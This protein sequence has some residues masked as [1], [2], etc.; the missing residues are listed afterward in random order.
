MSKV[1]FA[2]T[3]IATVALGATGATLAQNPVLNAGF[4]QGLDGWELRI[5]GD[6]GDVAVVESGAAGRQCALITKTDSTPQWSAV[7]IVQ[8][9]PVE[10]NAVYQLSL[11]SRSDLEEKA[12]S[13]AFR[14]FIAPSGAPGEDVNRVIRSSDDWAAFRWEYSTGPKTERITVSILLTYSSGKVWIDDVRFE[15]QGQS[16]EAESFPETSGARAAERGSLSG[17]RGVALTGESEIATRVRLPE[18][19]IAV[20]VFGESGDE[21]L[22]RRS[23]R[24][25]LGDETKIV[26]LHRHGVAVH[27]RVAYFEVDAAG[28]RELVIS[29]TPDYEGEVVVDRVFW[30]T[31]DGPAR[32]KDLRLHTVLVQSGEP[33]A[34]I[35]ASDAPAMRALADRLQAEIRK[36]SGATLPVMR[37]EELMGGEYE[38]TTAIAI[39]NLMQNKLS[40]RLYCLWYTREDGW[41]PGKG[42]YVIRSVH[43]LWGTGANVLVLAGSDEQGT[44]DAVNRLLKSLKPGRDIVLG[45]TI[46]VTMDPDVAA[47]FGSPDAD[48]AVRSLP[49]R[50]QRSLMSTSA[51]SGIAYQYTGDPGWADVFRVYLMEHKRRPE[52][53]HDTHMELW[54][55]IRAWDVLEECPALTDEDRLE[56][57]N[58]LLYVLRSKEGV[59]NSMFVGSLNYSSVRHNHHMLAALDAYY[60]GLYFKHYY[61][62]PDADDWLAKARFCFASQELQDKGQDE[63]GNYEGS[64]SLKS[65]V[66]FAYGEPGYRFLPSGTGRRFLDRVAM[67]IDNRFSSSGHGD[68]WDVNCFPA[69]ALRVGAWYYGDGRYQYILNGRLRERPN[70][71]SAWGGEPPFWMDGYLA[72][73]RP[74][75]LEGL[76]VARV[77]EEF[78]NYYKQRQAEKLRFNVPRDEAFDKISFRTAF[79]PDKQYLLLDGI[80]IGSHGHEDANCLIRFTDNDRVWLVDDSYTEGPFL[81]DHNGVKV[82]RNG[83]AELMP[84][85]ARLDVAA[86]L[87][88]VGLTRTTLPG[89]SGVDWERNIFWLKEQCFVVL[90]RMKAVRSGRYSLRCLWRTLGTA[91][92]EGNRLVTRQEAQTPERRDAFHIVHGSGVRATVEAEREVFGSRWAGRYPYAEPVVNIHSQ[93][94]RAELA[95]G[96]AFTFANLFYA[97]N[98]RQPH[99]L[100]IVKLDDETAFIEG[101]MEAIVGFADN[102]RKIGDVEVRADLFVIWEDGCALANGTVLRIGGKEAFTSPTPVSMQIEAGK[103]TA[104][105]KVGADADARRTTVEVPPSAFAGAIEAARALAERLRSAI[106]AGGP[107]AESSPNI[108]TLWTFDAGSSVRALAAHDLSGRGTPDVLLG[109]ADGAGIALDSKGRERWRIEAEGAINDVAAGNLGAGEAAVF[110]SD[111]TK[112]YAVDADGKLLWRFACPPYPKRGGKNGAAKYLHVAD[113]DGDGRAEVIVGAN[114]IQLHVLNPDGTERLNFE[115]SDAHVTFSGFVTQD[116][117]GDGL[118]E[119]LSFPAS[120]SFGHWHQFSLD[121]TARRFGTDGWPSHIRD[122]AAADLN[123]DGRPDFACGT[124]RGNIYYIRQAEDGLQQERVFSSGCGV[125]AM[126]GHSRIGEPGVIAVG[127]DVSYVHLLDSAGELRWSRDT[128]GPPTDMVFLPRKSTPPLLA[129]GATDGSIIFYG[130]D[131]SVVGR[132]VGTSRVNAL[133]AVGPDIDSDAALLAASADGTVTALQV[134]AR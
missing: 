59:N 74:T 45:H 50:G 10:P 112:V 93:D 52:L 66:P 110:V 51:R 73:E 20:T 127:L 55:T 5:N 99:D 40:E 19:A 64:T 8:E 115:C 2:V 58:Y 108:Q 91:A 94:A 85:C 26:D 118:L 27:G 100:D 1:C 57:T 14:A 71:K 6:M 120:G 87:G 121:G 13:H 98:S 119:I 61:G 104:V 67:S 46:D 131:G 72:A 11:R 32:V 128:G 133:C 114:N 24:V 130:L 134:T 123:G 129:V 49:R 122:V 92:L 111:D 124:N 28:E 76:R 12:V 106:P 109:T 47:V 56:V 37:D 17:G 101:D 107:L 21:D 29:R 69:I 7:G 97:T 31:Y 95:P 3:L 53:G 132:F 68:C 25:S 105:L 23:V 4:E 83:I 36:L 79:E 62:L 89:H 63:S 33:R 75:D 96:E 88:S 84:G 65:L 116:V 38:Q 113:L 44:R 90:D 22:A 70:E 103:G 48:Y 30:R 82:A 86:D 54:K 18:G 77:N 16:I 80:A 9:V 117:D 43:D 125:T 102:G 60:G 41:Y 34:S 78:Y 126:A 81:T 35:V 39:G 42:G 15:K